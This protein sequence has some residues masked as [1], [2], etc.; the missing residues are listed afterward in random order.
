MVGD[1]RSKH[2]PGQMSWLILISDCLM[3]VVSGL[4]FLAILKL[5]RGAF[6]F[7]KGLEDFQFSDAL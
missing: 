5:F 4:G 1:W 6:P 2:R 3:E 7:F